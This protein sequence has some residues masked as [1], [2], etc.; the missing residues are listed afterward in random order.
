[1]TLT[2]RKKQI[3]NAT[4]N[5]YIQTAE[6]VGS[7]VLLEDYEFGVSSATVRQELHEL[8]EDGFL[9]HLHTSSGRIPTELGYRFYVDKLMSNAPLTVQ[10]HA[11]ISARLGSMSLHLGTALTQVSSLMSSLIDYTTIV[12]VPTIYQDVLKLVHMVLVDIN[13]VLVILLHSLGV[14][15]EFILNLDEHLD[16]ADL[17]RLSQCLT[18]KLEGMNIQD[19]R[20]EFFAQISMDLPDYR[21]VLDQLSVE[22]NRL[23]AHHQDDQNLILSGTSKMLKLPEFKNI[24]FTQQVLSAIEEN[25]VLLELLKRSLSRRD[26]DQSVFIG[27]SDHQVELLDGCSVVLKPVSIGPFQSTVIGVLGP[28]RMTYSAVTSKLTTLSA[29]VSGYLTHS[30]SK[31]GSYGPST[32]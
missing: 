13:R 8:E 11:F 14:N 31:G 5:R 20:Q 23:K 19:I 1:M 10:E 15:H 3:L 26:A 7:K 30:H 28:T 4:V 2:E 22:I 9:T 29:M 27:K 25:K 6:P 16:Q 17:N 18:S 32:N 12:M 21:Y 24:E